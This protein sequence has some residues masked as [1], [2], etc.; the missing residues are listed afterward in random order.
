[1]SKLY[2]SVDS[3]LLNAIQACATKAR[4]Q[5]IENLQPPTKAPALEKGSLMHTCLEI[6]DGLRGKCV[7]EDSETWQ[8]LREA[9]LYLYLD[10]LYEFTPDEITKFAVEAGR[11]FASRMEVSTEDSA[12]VLYQMKEYADF[13]RNDPWSTLAVEEIATRVMYEDDEL[14]VLYTGKI[15][16]V[17]EQGNIRAPMDHKTSERRQDP[18]SLSNQFIGYCWILGMNNIIIDKIGFQKTLKPVERFQRYIL[19]IDEARINEWWLN[20]I[21][22]IRSYVNG[23]LKT[24]EFSMNLT[25]C[26][27]YGSCI[28][29]SLCESNPEG[30]NWRK[31]R[32]YIV[33]E[34]WDPSKVLEKQ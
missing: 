5:F 29:S 18:S 17:V 33:G 3:Q 1:M 27:K 6:Y 30:R 31:E 22:W 34:V 26:D 11:M 25:S 28:Y 13:Y 23:S 21:T 15:D 9:H 32:D 4:Y 12:A 20:S 19:T 8:S 7:N 10:G 24:G 14:Q 2:L 16:R